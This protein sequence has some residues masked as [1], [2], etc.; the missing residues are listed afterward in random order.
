MII[1]HATAMEKAGMNVIGFML[2]CMKSQR[3]TK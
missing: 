3:M 1:E 2:D